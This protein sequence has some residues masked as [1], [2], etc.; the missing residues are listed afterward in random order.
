LSPHG[1]TKLAGEWLLGD[2]ATASGLAAVSLRFAD[3]GGAADPGL[4]DTDTGHLLPGVFAA[5]DAGT[6]PVVAGGD[7]TT[8]DG[9]AVRD[10]VHVADVADAHLAAVRALEAGSPGG[11]Y[12]VGT[13]RGSSVLDVLRVVA[14]VTGGDTTPELAA[15]RPEEPASVVPD[16]RRVEGE[17]GT[18]AGRD[19]HDVVTSAW[20]AWR[21][22]HPL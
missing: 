21:H 14:E 1:R 19:L 4:G 11:V 6:A 18:R 13:G 15:R 16:V 3:V 10:H 12:N 22:L 2:C 17:L 8:G 20:T 7:H 9:T 5:L